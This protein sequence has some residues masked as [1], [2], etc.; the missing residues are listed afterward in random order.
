MLHVPW[1]GASEPRERVSYCRS[2]DSFWGTCRGMARL[3]LPR[4]TVC[5]FPTHRNYA[6]T[7]VSA[8]GFEPGTSGRTS[9]TVNVHLIIILSTA[10]KYTA[11]S[12]RYALTELN[13]LG[14]SLN[15][16]PV[17]L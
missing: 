2:A 4:A 1:L 3:S 11:P 7:Q 6:V 15:V 5:K 14:E 12:K 16:V 13:A 9:L 8:T 17:D 10:T